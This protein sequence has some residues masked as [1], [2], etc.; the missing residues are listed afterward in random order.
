MT[1]NMRMMAK[2]ISLFMVVL[3]LKWANLSS[4]LSVLIQKL[5][6]LSLLDSFVNLA[7]EDN[8]RQD[9][10]E[11][12]ED[13]SEPIYVEPAQDELHKTFSREQAITLKKHPFNSVVQP[14]KPM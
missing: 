14:I 10:K 3:D 12:G 8:K 11:A 9:R 1:M 7:V 2:L 4:N 6:K 13:K 5:D